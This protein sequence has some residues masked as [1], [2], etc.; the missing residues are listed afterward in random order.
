MTTQAR[1]KAWLDCNIFVS[2]S[3]RGVNIEQ[4]Y[5]NFSYIIT[6]QENACHSYEILTI[7]HIENLK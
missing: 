2:L 3:D 1:L 5:S 6:V 7:K 4:Q